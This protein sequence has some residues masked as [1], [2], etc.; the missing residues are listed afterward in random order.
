MKSQNR[1]STT[2]VSFSDLEVVKTIFQT[3][4]IPMI[5]IDKQ[6]NI[7]FLN[8]AYK[9]YLHVNNMNFL[10]KNVRQFISNSRLPMV[11]RTKK[12][13]IGRAHV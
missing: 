4:P 8:D 2:N 9:S 13:Q 12:P 11:L 7:I 6:E 10:G 5:I 1:L 3:L